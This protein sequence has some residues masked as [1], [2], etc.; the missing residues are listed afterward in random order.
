[1]LTVPFTNT[2]VCVCVCSYVCMCVHVYVC[3]FSIIS[4]ESFGL[5]FGP[6]MLCIV[7]QY[8]LFDVIPVCLCVK[9]TIKKQNYQ[10]HVYSSY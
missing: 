6:A 10:F 1:M 3:V 4:V 2:N 5:A 9:I 7:G 8:N